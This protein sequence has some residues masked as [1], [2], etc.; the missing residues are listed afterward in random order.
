MA[1]TRLRGRESVR[2]I[3][4]RAVGAN[5]RLRRCAQSS[6]AG[7]PKRSKMNCERASGCAGQ[8]DVEVLLGSLDRARDERRDLLDAVALEASARRAR[9]AGTRPPPRPTVGA[10]RRPGR[11]RA[12]AGGASATRP[13]AG[14]TRRKPVIAS[15]PRNQVGSGGIDH[16]ASS[17]SIDDDARRRRRAAA[18]P[19]SA[20]TISLSSLVA[21]RAQRL[22]LAALGQLV[23][24]R[25]A[26]P[27]QRAVDRRDGRLERRRRPPWPRS[28]A[29]RAGSAPRAGWRAGAAAPRRTRARGSRA[30]RSGPPARRG[31][32][33]R[34]ASRPGRAR[35]T[36]SR[37]AACAE[38]VVRVGRR[39]V[40]DR[41]HALGPPRDLVQAGV[42]G[43]RVEPRAQR[44]AALEAR[45][46]APRAQR[47]LLQRVLG[48]VHR[49]EH[50][51]A[52]GVELAAVGLEQ[53][54]ERVLV[55][56]RGPPRAARARARSSV[57][58]PTPSRASVDAPP[59][60]SQTA[61]PIPARR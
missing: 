13:T 57:C 31:R 20:S 47:G 26:R 36:P 56:R 35:P 45:E 23:V 12:R 25:L 60:R 48:V 61:R 43:D 17:A 15:R 16:A 46:A 14:R 49:A 21:E 42:R 9:T 1:G 11:S 5:A 2:R 37:R 55:A 58:R 29:P 53:L 4:V 27:L 41:Q 51:V 59:R 34:R 8:F 3:P 54:R 40:V 32:P 52:V 19:C 10:D 30:A 18:R 7:R 38:P 24:D 50:P 39:A 6:R 22:L 28:R 33:R 44:A